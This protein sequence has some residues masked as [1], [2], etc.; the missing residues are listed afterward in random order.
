[1]AKQKSNLNTIYVGLSG[2]A[3][4]PTTKVLNK[5]DPS[6]DIKNITDDVTTDDSTAPEKMTVYAGVITGAK[7]KQLVDTT[8]PSYDFLRQRMEDGAPFLFCYR[9]DGDGTPKRQGVCLMLVT[10]RPDQRQTTKIAEIEWN[11]EAT[12]GTTWTNQ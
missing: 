2:G 8:D 12:G 3:N 6:V 9:P 10:N 1:M 7:F 11:L 5:S 4:P